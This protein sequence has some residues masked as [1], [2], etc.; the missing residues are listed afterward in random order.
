[1]DSVLGKLAVGAQGDYKVITRR[2]K[3]MRARLIQ[4]GNSRGVRLPRALI[5][6]ARLGDELEIT[7][8]EGAVVIRGAA[9]RTGWATDAAA[10]RFA[11][12]DELADWSSTTGDG[13]WR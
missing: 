1:M 9:V 6:Q 11:S 2:E 10:C 7:V 13:D 3:T 5:E 4:I 8:E 12:D